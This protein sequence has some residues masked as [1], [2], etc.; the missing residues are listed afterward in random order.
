MICLILMACVLGVF[1]RTV[2]YNFVA[3]DD[4]VY[5]VDNPHIQEGLNK[6]SLK[7]AFTSTYANFWHPVTWLSYILDVELFGTGP[8]GFH[9]SNIFWHYVNTLL[10][11]AV[12]YRMTHALWP[13]LTVALLFGIHPLHVESVAWV[14]EKKDL[15][16]TFFMMLAMGAY[17]AYAKNQTRWRY[18][19][20]TVLFAIGLMAKP[21]IVTLP[22]VFLLLDYWPLKRNRANG[23]ESTQILHAWRLVKEKIPFFFLAAVFSVV[24]VVA[25]QKGGTLAST[26]EINFLFRIKNAWVSYF[27]YLKNT[28]YPSELSIFYPYPSAIPLWTAGAA[29]FFVLTMTMTVLYFRRNC[30]WLVTGWFWYLGTLVPVIGLVQ[31]GDFSM[32]DRFSYIPLIG[33]FIM[34]AWTA[35]NVGDRRPRLRKWLVLFLS[36]AIFVLG[37]A[38]YRHAGHFRDSLTL[39]RHAIRMDPNNWLALNNLG[40]TYNEMGQHEKAIQCFQDALRIKP[41]FIEALNN[42]A[43][44]FVKTGRM[45]E[46]LACYGRAIEL[47]PDFPGTYYNLAVALDASGRLGDAERNYEKALK[48]DP[49]NTAALNNLGVI[50]D[51]LRRTE[52]GIHNIQKALEIDPNYAEA[53]YNMGNLFLR[54]SMPDGAVYHYTR[55]IKIKPD[56]AEAYNNFGVAMLSMDRVTAAIRLF[57]SALKIRS[58]YPD[59]RANL[60]NARKRI[61]EN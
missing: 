43:G 10:L 30:P 49:L 14:S 9:L 23:H 61:H 2:T 19:A 26:G 40:V 20:V 60:K 15:V 52:E 24:A 1:G 48:M 53:H 31:V 25:Q 22:F 47:M 18:G 7:W 11:F 46:G 44:V 55:A 34:F 45:D 59:A 56:Y 54:K 36:V 21:M 35:Q 3:Y 28:V 57:Q 16:S 33:I 42:L 41:V 27:C 37:V 5:V 4:Y 13:C 38:G 32:A 58:D 39:F 17:G 50:Q 29:A 12:F 51:R 6:K 8:A